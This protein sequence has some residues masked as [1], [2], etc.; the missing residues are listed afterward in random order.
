MFSMAPEYGNS[1]SRISC[2]KFVPGSGSLPILS[3][4][5]TCT[6]S[7]CPNF[8]MDNLTISG[9]TWSGDTDADN[10]IVDVF[11]VA[12]HNNIY[13]GT[14]VNINHTAWQGVGAFGDNSWASADT[15]GAAGAFYVE[16][17]VLEGG[18]GN[19][20]LTDTNGTP[21]DGAGRIVCRF[22][23]GSIPQNSSPCYA[24]GTETGGRPRG[25][26]QMENYANSMTCVTGTT[27]QSGSTIRSGTLLQFGNYYPIA[28]TGFLSNYAIALTERA[29]R[30]TDWGL[31][32]G[33]GPWDQDAG[34]SNPVTTTVSSFSNPTITVAATLSSGAYN[35]SSSSPGANYYTV[36][37]TITGTMAGIASN[38]TGAIT[39]SWIT[40]NFSGNTNINNG[41]GL[42]ILGSTLSAAGTFTGS[43]GAA[44]L[45]DSSKTWSTNQWANYSVLDVTANFS[46]Q[47]VSNTATGTTCNIQQYSGTWTS[48]DKYVIMQPTQ[49]LDQSGV[50]GGPLFSGTVPAPHPTA[51][52]A[53][54]IYEWDDGG[55][56]FH[57]ALNVDNL[58]VSSYSQTSGQTA[59]TS[60]TSPFN[61]TSGVGWG[62]LA[63]RPTTCTTGV[64]YWA[65]DQGSWNT[66]GITYNGG[67]TQGELFKCTATNTW[68]LSYTPYTYPHP[69]DG[70]GTPSYTLTVTKTGNGTGTLAGTN[71]SSGSYTSGT[72]ITCTESWT[73]G[74]VFTSWGGACSGMGACSFSLTANA[75]VTAN[76]VATTCQSL[77]QDANTPAS[78]PGGSSPGWNIDNTPAA[79]GGINTPASVSQTISNSSPAGAPSGVSMLASETTIATS[80][81]T[82][83]LFWD[84][85]PGC[86]SATNFVQDKW[87]YVTNIA[88]ANNIEID[89]DQYN[90]TQGRLYSFGG[91][92]HIGG[93]W[94][95][96]N[97]SSGWQNTSEACSLP[98]GWHHIIATFHRVNGDTSCSGVS[99]NYYDSRTVDGTTYNV[100]ATLPN[101]SL[102]SDPTALVDQV[103]IDAGPTTGTAAT[104]SYNLDEVNFSAYGATP[105][106]ASPSLLLLSQ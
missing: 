54:P 41:D 92:C 37:D 47:I 95:Y 29:Y 17:N 87:I 22:N 46:C 84:W 33:A 9:T 74:N 32:S 77:N 97:N 10:D 14:L 35:F 2:L 73:S 7:G 12:D 78:G 70:G 86:D 65:T 93:Y 39:I 79:T 69:L 105:S 26:R 21:S 42:K 5:G 75:S 63:Y 55:N 67:Y 91:Q 24:H 58:L 48:G 40:Q 71:C 81:Q 89:S 31:A 28:G 15:F 62:T 57:A 101:E 34:A 27:C 36:L 66:S 51:Q 96:A 68:T 82:N 45:I 61:G 94:Q 1:E 85:L 23:S 80:T 100:N 102:G 49:I 90:Y 4:Y 3:I 38:T 83:A 98:A 16:N 88:A 30:E 76:F 59:Q 53:D 50:S 25:G 106:G 56:A 6:S 52:T 11:G 8:R 13:D 64:G 104:V 60:A 18:A 20:N 44:N 103:Q 99:C 19:P 72:T 43:T